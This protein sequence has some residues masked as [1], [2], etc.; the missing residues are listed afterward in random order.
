MSP[1]KGI[2]FFLLATALT[3]S[4]NAQF[5]LRDGDR[6]V[7]YGDSITD[8]A[9]YTKWIE[10][11]VLNQFPKMKVR[12]FNA[13][14]GG[15]T[16]N[17]GWS[18][19][20]DVRLDRDLFR[21]KP[22]VVTIML[23]MNDGKYNAGFDQPAF[24]AFKSGYEHILDRIQAESPLTRVWLLRPSPYDD[25]TRPSFANTEGY[26]RVLQKYGDA[27]AE[28][29]TK[30]SLGLIDMNA[31]MVETLKK[32]FA[33]KPEDAKKIIEDRVHPSYPGHLAMTATLLKG[34][35]TPSFVS[36]TEID[37]AKREI[38]GIGVST[39]RLNVSD[40]ITWT[41]TEDSLPF[42]IDHKDALTQFV[43]RNSDVE[44][45]LG[46][47]VLIVKNLPPGNYKLSI[48]GKDIYTFSAETYSTGVDLSWLPTPM[49]AQSW[50][51]YDLVQKRSAISY[52]SWRTIQIPLRDLSLKSSDEA[53]KVL[54]RLD[55]DLVKRE[56]QE[57]TPKPHRFSL[58]KV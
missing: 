6:V 44:D 2:S 34:W 48:D 28:M 51:V 27:I 39:G 25:V 24:E 12:F 54:D 1:I 19:P 32:A 57:A 36:R 9:P 33:E 14:V 58:S 29:A 52:S 4:A 30:R 21:H 20:V 22:T 18:G 53:V 37:V 13:G 31:P 46:R 17:G 5:A 49:Q 41:S 45:T 38:R 55:E 56:H 11:Y 47:E 15:D 43:L 35:G 50:R 23:G 16:V 42:P 8:N 40:T 26:N 7:F 10:T 3:G